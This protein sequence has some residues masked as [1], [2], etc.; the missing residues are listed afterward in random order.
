MRA[1][2]RALERVVTAVPAGFLCRPF[3][4]GQTREGKPPRA[5]KVAGLKHAMTFVAGRWACQACGAAR[6]RPQAAR[7]LDRAECP[8][9]HRLLD[10]VHESHQILTGWLGG[11]GLG[12]GPTD[13][14]LP[15]VICEG[16][17]FYGSSRIV[18]LARECTRSTTD[19]R[20]RGL[21][22]AA[23]GMHPVKAVRESVQELRPL[24]RR[25]RRE[26]LTTR[27]G[28]AAVNT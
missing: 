5:A 27:G 19:A 10:Q 17:G 11:G 6:R 12:N 1:A 25:E 21:E 28:E 15:F 7:E 13:G 8:G 26:Q 22:P 24:P 20:R 9:R 14:R 4:M 18:G 16:C 23:G 2:A 3:G